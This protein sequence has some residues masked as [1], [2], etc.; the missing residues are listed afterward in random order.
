MPGQHGTGFATEAAQRALQAAYEDFN[1]PTAVSVVAEKNAASQAVAQ[2]LGAQEE[3]RITY[4]H[5]PAIVYRHRCT[6]SGP[7]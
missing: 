7:G 5:G 2:R 3:S 6:E 4:R 1:W